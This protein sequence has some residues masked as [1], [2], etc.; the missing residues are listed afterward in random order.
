M[1]LLSAR[2]RVRVEYL[3]PS[4]AGRASSKQ[5]RI[6]IYPH[7]EDQLRLYAQYVKSYSGLLRLMFIQE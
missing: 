4:R 7:H 2:E 3:N 5:L 1:A 6:P